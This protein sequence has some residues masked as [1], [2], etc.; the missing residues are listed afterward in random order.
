M[1]DNV[2]TPEF[3]LSFPSLF[4]PTKPASAKPEQKE[5]YG[6]AMIFGEGADLKALTK[7]RDAAAKE[8]WGDNIPKGLRNPIKDQGESV[9]K[10]GEI[11][12]GYTD[13]LFY[14]NASSLQ[15]PGVV[16]AQVESI[17][18]ESEIYAGCYARA[19]VRAFAYGGP[20][21]G[22]KAGVSFGLQ[23][24][25]KLRDGDPLG[26]RTKA[27]DDFAPIDGGD[28]GDVADQFG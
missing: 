20:G 21:T 28:T 7:A 10:N 25:Q 8:K 2:L 12:D 18:D 16:N 4:V 24:V 27:E 6:C 5:K 11:R 23:N 15:R 14:I 3:R 22:F 19:T 17:I 1:S 9:D 26:G 13:G